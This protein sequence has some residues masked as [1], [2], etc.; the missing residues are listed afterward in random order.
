MRFSASAALAGSPKGGR[1]A[2]EGSRAARP[3]IKT[4][5][6]APRTQ[7][8]GYGGVAG[9]VGRVERRG[10]RAFFLEGL[11]G[12]PSVPAKHTRREEPRNA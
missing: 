12:G 7:R 6:A 9:L 11:T 4:P 10:C 2:R 5:D 8:F 3:S 1:P